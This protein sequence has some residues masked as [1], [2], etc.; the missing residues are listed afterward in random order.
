M[1]LLD[2]I[3]ALFTPQGGPRA[4]G[5]PH[6]VWYYFRCDRCGTVVRIRA[7]R[8]NDF[9]REENGPG[10]LVL[11][12]EVMDDKCF[13]LIRAEIWVDSSYQPVSAEVSGGSLI[14]REEYQ[15]AV[16]AS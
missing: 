5:D 8:R 6:G 15:K 9:N 12:K 16:D 7:D 10:A 11:R 14:T 13:Q 1:S 4:S 3:K 2:R